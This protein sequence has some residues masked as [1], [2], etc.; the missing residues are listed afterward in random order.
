[1]RTQIDKLG[2]VAVTVEKDYWDINKDYDK[3]TIV[4]VEKEY[5]TY[6]SRKPVPA[7]T[8]LTDKN[9]WI[10]FSS[11]KEE[12]V[13]DYNKFLD[14]YKPIIDNISELSSLIENNTNTLEVLQTEMGSIGD[15]AITNNDNIN[16]LL[17]EI[18]ALSN[19]VQQLEREIEKNNIKLYLKYN[20]SSFSEF[21]SN[22]II[23]YKVISKVDVTVEVLIDS[24]QLYSE[25][26]VA[27]DSG[28]KQTPDITKRLCY[29]N[30]NLV[31]VKV[32]VYDGTSI[33]SANTVI[34][35]YI[36]FSKV[37]EPVE[38]DHVCYI[39]DQRG[40]TN[41]SDTM[42][43][44]NYMKNYK[45]ELVKISDDAVTSNSSINFLKYLKENTHAYVGEITQSG[46]VLAQLND[47]NRHLM[48]NGNSSSQYI[49]RDGYDF[50]IKFPF[51][52]W[53]KTEAYTPPSDTTVNKDYILVT[54]ASKK[55]D[56][57]DGWN[58][59]DSNQL[60]AVYEA[61]VIGT[62]L[63]S[64][65][66]IKPISES[67]NTLYN[68]ARNK[69]EGFKLVTYEVHKLMCLLF[70]GY[71]GTLDSQKICGA[72][73]ITFDDDELTY[74]SK[75][76]GNTDYLGMHDTVVATGEGYPE[77]L[78]QIIAGTGPDIKSI[79]FWGL[80]NWWG[81]MSECLDNLCI[82]QLKSSTNNDAYV[83]VLD[84]LL[85][86]GTITITNGS[87]VN[88]TYTNTSELL[89]DYTEDTHMFLAEFDEN[90]DAVIKR[91]IDL[92]C[93]VGVRYEMTKRMIFGTNADV[94]SSGESANLNTNKYYTDTQTYTQPGYEISRGGHSDNR[95]GGISALNSVDPDII[96][97]T[98]GA[99][100]MYVG[101]I[102][103]L[104]NM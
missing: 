58:K 53:Y 20:N 30:K 4:Y 77:G 25:T 22:T 23:T 21:D 100:L 24:N 49:N 29:T 64:S 104:D 65:P 38:L 61:G 59:F 3:L 19:D 12:I 34:N 62:K 7:G 48:T 18:S 79:N 84:Y 8:V 103:Y 99:R 26:I 2:K 69:G 16:L 81:D 17:T 96:D 89:N 57:T 33:D 88:K 68:Y 82:M 41:D 66:N 92:Q 37:D 56:N 32:R 90:N 54:I 72:G 1:M 6:I 10:P 75:I 63:I 11:L 44:A 15:L 78:D 45:G 94:I 87:G 71:Y 101:N 83:Y 35:D 42:V 36:V 50:W 102:E 31:A 5:A 40:N 52:I 67:F 51:D 98:V 93:L 14:T 76:T 86:N 97:P 74:H 27:N 55:L 9:Y 13:I 46:I 91:V 47:N 73:T 60:I 43:S 95:V 80:E 85:E 28:W 70:Y 39:I